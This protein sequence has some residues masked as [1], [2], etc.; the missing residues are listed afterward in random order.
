MKN[1][2]LL[3]YLLIGNRNFNQFNEFRKKL[4]FVLTNLYGF[5]YWKILEFLLLIKQLLQNKKVEGIQGLETGL[6]WA[7]GIVKEAKFSKINGE[8]IKGWK[9]NK[10]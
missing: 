6:G 7:K 4:N 1:E 2:A 10:T 3:F 9:R 8:K 5:S